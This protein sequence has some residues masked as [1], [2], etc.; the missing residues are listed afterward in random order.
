M[1]KT[2][3]RAPKFEAVISSDINVEA[4]SVSLLFKAVDSQEYA[5]ELDVPIISSTVGALIGTATQ[6][7]PNLP[8]EYQRLVQPLQTTGMN[9]SMNSDGSLGFEIG[10][11][12]GLKI[13]LK[14]QQAELS[15]LSL[16]IDEAMHLSD[17]KNLN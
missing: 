2:V 12:G 11:E 7:I 3:R 6:L 15:Q 4:R 8:E 1:S 9:L 13:L 10:L 14:L 16:M 5:I 17:K